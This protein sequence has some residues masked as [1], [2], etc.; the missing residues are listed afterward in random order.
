MRDGKK[1]KRSLGPY[2]RIS[3]ADARR[4]AEN[5][6]EKTPKPVPVTT[7]AGLLADWARTETRK[8]MPTLTRR[9]EMY[10]AS[11]L[12]LP[13]TDISKSAIVSVLEATR[14]T[15]KIR[16]AG[17]LFSTLKRLFDYAL[18]HELIAANPMAALKKSKYGNNGEE[19]DRVFS[20][21]EIPLFMTKIRQHLPVKYWR[22]LLLQLS[23]ATRIGETCLAKIEHFDLNARTWFIPAKNNK[24]K[25]DFTVYLSDF[26]LDVAKSA[27]AERST[28]AGYLFPG[29]DPEAP[30]SP[31]SIAK[32][33]LDKQAGGL[34]RPNRPKDTAA[35]L[36]PGGLWTS[37]DVR[38]TSATLMRSSRV[39]VD[40]VEAC[41]NH[42]E[43]DRMKRIYHRHQTAG[44]MRAAWAALSDRLH[45]FESASQ[46][47]EARKK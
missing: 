36:M 30:I 6:P 17:D 16:T 4:L 9:V 26:A 21:E 28:S 38:R 14:A 34:P 24:S 46:L 12:P 18:D 13:I 35:L 40:I 15:G 45:K 37:H 27:M 39:A 10:A 7:V 8:D 19:G 22:I 2:P 20:V 3:L 11:L 42:L 29:R 25:R 43:N 44:E 33:I 31:K 1:T 32:T 47:P 41:L 23:C 5:P